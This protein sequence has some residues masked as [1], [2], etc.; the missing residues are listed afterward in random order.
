MANTPDAACTVAVVIPCYNAAPYLARA[1]D[2]VF[3]QTYLDFHIYLIDDGSTDDIEAAL[4][5]YIGRIT[6]SRHPHA[7]QA[8]ARNRGILV[9]NSRYIAFLDADDEWLPD[10]LKRQIEVLQNLP[11]TA[12]A[13]S[14]CLTSGSGPSDGSYF[15][16]TGIPAGGNIFDRLARTCD[17]HT[18]TVMVR[19]EC[20]NDVGLFNESL[21]VG[22]DYNLW[23][24]IA[25]RWDVAV[26]PEALAIRHVTIGSLSLTTARDRALTAVIAAFEDVARTC[27]GLSRHQRDALRK[28]LAKRCYAYGSHLLLIGSRE[29]ARAQFL[30]AIHDGGRDWRTFAKLGLTFVPSPM[31]NLLDKVRKRLVHVA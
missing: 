1:L 11:Q 9:S 13:Y 25:S 21:P 31:F 6:W 27:P 10:K 30:R 7:G 15:A 28:G 12:M 8:A 14:D 20:L 29:T 3:A 17:I 22:E 19:R 4:L 24:R 2:S 5:P 26:V 18:P 23:L 16:R